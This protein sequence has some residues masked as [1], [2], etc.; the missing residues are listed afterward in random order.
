MIFEILI[1]NFISSKLNDWRL[2]VEGKGT[3]EII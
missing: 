2:N 1:V 3:A